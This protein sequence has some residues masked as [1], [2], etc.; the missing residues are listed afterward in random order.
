MRNCEL[1][2]ESR[3]VEALE[4]YQP[5]TFEIHHTPDE[6]NRNTLPLAYQTM[7]V[8][9]ISWYPGVYFWCYGVHV[10]AEVETRWRRWRWWAAGSSS[11]TSE[12][13]I[14]WY[15]WLLRMEKRERSGWL[16]KLQLFV[17]CFFPTKQRLE[18]WTV[19]RKTL[20]QKHTDEPCLLL[21]SC[22]CSARHAPGGGT[23][24]F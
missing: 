9:V 17:F 3:R 1:F 8:G 20:S 15:H 19:Y 10:W 6:T 14:K 21:T 7:Y 16:N 18:I 22:Y 12:W 23:Y 13:S 4:I 2:S 5:I 24:M 11:D